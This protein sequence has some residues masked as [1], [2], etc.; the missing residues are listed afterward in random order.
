MATVRKVCDRVSYLSEGQIQQ[1]FDKTDFPALEQFIK[2]KV[3]D[4]T[5]AAW[6]EIRK[7]L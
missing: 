6:A 3:H 1:T 2:T 4:R 7:P 5:K